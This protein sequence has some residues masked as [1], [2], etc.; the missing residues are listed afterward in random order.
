MRIKNIICL[1]ICILS[2]LSGCSSK[3]DIIATENGE[4]SF[5]Y[6]IEDVL[7]FT[8]D[9]K[10]K[11][12]C[13]K[14]NSTSM[15]CFDNK[16][17]LLK[18]YEIGEGSNTN[19][20]IENNYIYYISSV[21]KGGRALKRLD[22]D[23]GKVSE[24][25]INK[26]EINTVRSMEVINNNIYFLRWSDNYDPE[27]AQVRFDEYDD[28][29][30]MGEIATV[31]DIDKGKSVPIDIKNVMLFTK[32]DK[33]SLLFYAYDDIGGFYFTFFDTQEK[34]FSDK[35]YNNNI[36]QIFSFAYDSDN[37][38]IIYLK[39]IEQ[40]L[41]ATDRY[42]TKVKA[43]LLR[44]V[45]ALV[46]NDTLYH[47][48]HTY[49]LD[50]ISGKIKCIDN[51]RAIKDNKPLKIYQTNYYFKDAPPGCGYNII[52][53]TVS[54]EELALILLS[55]DADYDLCLM[56]SND[57][58]SRSIRDKEPF[59][60]LND[61]PE[62]MTYLDACFPYLKEAASSK[63]GDIWMI[64]IAVNVNCIVYHED[65]CISEGINF[66]ET[67]STEELLQ[68]VIAISDKPNTRNKYSFPALSINENAIYQYINF[69][70]VKDNKANFD[71]TL[72]KDIC[73]QM[74]E[75][76]SPT[77]LHDYT[78]SI[79]RVSDIE[80]DDYYDKYLFELLLYKFTAYGDNAYN[81]LRAIPLPPIEPGVATP[82][83]VDCTYVSI[84]PNSSN[85]EN[86]LDYISD[87]CVA[88]ATQKDTF[89]LQDTKYYSYSDS[90]LTRD[91]YDIYS[92]GIVSFPFSY[93]IFWDDYLRYHRGE[94]ELEKLI[95]EIERKVNAYLSE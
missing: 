6:D 38:K 36:G 25:S 54:E 15:Y 46:G 41:Y 44:G 79:Y 91:L 35:T 95:K 37:D 27:Q 9:E 92:N 73:I 48:N 7:S 90:N 2:L 10:G 89:M 93:E 16:G 19:L 67:G 62:A 14:S 12:Y 21:E 29:Y 28:Y 75:I 45:V 56:S 50:N 22:I 34:Q 58:F 63:S 64:P 33:D 82:N 69:Y 65:N 13:S 17:K 42:D 49:I 52:S 77:L 71:T 72:F 31:Y 3:K 66:R 47:D 83:S 23:T 8:V 86:T 30:Y 57:D 11:L 24:L 51:V 60:P 78:S 94:M 80:N 68:N 39:Q 85:L 40:K 76:M 4:A 74:S 70:G 32:A 61:I 18:E 55:G 43:E 20:C 87:L 88:M 84:N 59:Y 26:E 1:T 5:T 53:E 81:R